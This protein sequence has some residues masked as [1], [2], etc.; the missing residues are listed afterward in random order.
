MVGVRVQSLPEAEIRNGNLD[1][2][3]R[4]T[5][6]I[7]LAAGTGRPDLPGHAIVLAQGDTALNPSTRLRHVATPTCAARCVARRSQ[8]R[9]AG[10]SLRAFEGVNGGYLRAL[11]V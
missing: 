8:A 9:S 3:V 4:S 2:Y 1:Q 11:D 5:E 10:K 6:K 7:Q